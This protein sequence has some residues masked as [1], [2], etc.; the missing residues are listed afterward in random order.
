MVTFYESQMTDSG[1]KN[2]GQN[3]VADDWENVADEQVIAQVAERQKQLANKQNEEKEAQIAAYDEHDQMP[4]PAMPNLDVRS[5]KLLKRPSSGTYI[6]QLA[7]DL[8]NMNGTSKAKSL[9]ERQAEYQ[10]VRE[11]I[12]GDLAASSTQGQEETP[13]SESP[14]TSVRGQGQ[15][16]LSDVP[17]K[18]AADNR[19]VKVNNPPT[20]WA[21]IPPPQ[22]VPLQPTLYITGTGV[23]P[24]PMP[25]MIPPPNTLPYGIPPPPLNPSYSQRGTFVSQQQVNPAMSMMPPANGYFQQPV[26]NFMQPPPT[27]EQTAQHPNFPPMPLSALTPVMPDKLTPLKGSGSNLKLQSRNNAQNPRQPSNLINNYEFPT[28]QQVMQNPPMKDSSYGRPPQFLLGQ[29]YKTGNGSSSSAT[30]Q[31]PTVSTTNNSQPHVNQ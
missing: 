23:F 12:F 5:I 25:G 19:R 6:N 13:C 9:E 24:A 16:H 15:N 30:I 26:Q 2:E 11:R 14:P 7:N 20:Q 28:L 1:Q 4:G 22:V 8:S 18:T 21:K 3:A 27:L 29:S 31:Q 17:M 10:R